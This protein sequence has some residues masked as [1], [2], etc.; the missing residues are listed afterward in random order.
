MIKSPSRPKVII[1]DEL[2]SSSLYRQKRPLLNPKQKILLIFICIFL[3]ACIL[4]ILWNIDQKRREE[5][6][7]REANF[8]FAKVL[9]EK[10]KSF[11]DH[12]QW[13]SVRLFAIYSLL[14]QAKAQKF[15]PMNDIDVPFDSSSIQLDYLTLIN[16]SSYTE[17][18][19]YPLVK[20][21]EKRT[22]LVLDGVTPVPAE[23]YYAI[24]L[25]FYKNSG[26]YNNALEAY[27]SA[28][29]FYNTGENLFKEHRFKDAIPAFKKSLQIRP[30]CKEALNQLGWSY[31][32]IGERGK[33]NQ[34]YKKAK[35]LDFDFYTRWNSKQW[36]N[37]GDSQ[38]KDKKYSKAVQSYKEALK[39]DSSFYPAWDN[40]GKT[41]ETLQQ[42]DKAIKLYKKALR[43]V[44]DSAPEWRGKSLYNEGLK[45]YT[46]EDIDTA[47]SRFKLALQEYP[48]LDRAWLKLADA[49]N[50]G[51]RIIYR[52]TSCDFYFN[53]AD[54]KKVLI[55][56][57]RAANLNMVIHHDTSGSITCR[58]DQVRWDKALDLF[59]KINNAGKWQVGDIYL[60]GSI[61]LVQ[62]LIESNDISIN[63]P[64]PSKKEGKRLDLS[65]F[66]ADAHYVMQNIAQKAGLKIIIDPSINI[67]ITCRLNQVPWY[68]AI[69][70]L[71]P[72]NDLAYFRLGKLLRIGKK[73]DIEKLVGNEQGMLDIT[74][75]LLKLDPG[76]VNFKDEKGKTM[77][78]YAA[79]KG[80]AQLTKYLISRGARVNIRDKWNFTPLHEAADKAVAEI[81]IDNGALVN[82]QSNS[83]LSPLQTAV[84]GL[85][86]ET[87]RF[88]V[89]K[90][91]NSNFFLDAAIG[92]LD[93]I[94]KQVSRNPSIVNNKGMG[95]WT[96]LHHATV[97]GQYPTVEFLISKGADLNALTS[98]GE[99]PLHLAVSRGH[100]SI[101]KLFIINGAKL[102]EKDKYGQTPLQIAKANEFKEIIKLLKK[103]GAQ[104]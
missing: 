53:R 64:H 72:L 18:E 95:D 98:K 63:N 1:S 74:R 77:L 33:S 27:H 62:K 12:Q 11:A 31:L 39:I 3:I 67:S 48:G 58:L 9:K 91:A 52:G 25:D 57:A 100:T 80:Y 94:K 68:T 37:L 47:I 102:N 82:I 54:L 61:P 35:E 96:P 20:D 90:R 8:N 29:D 45:N 2:H 70:V 43:H 66:E 15:L 60:I 22:G 44:P 83:G 84:Y 85:R 51:K 103:Y 75:S 76:H 5:D 88:L 34:I 23:I 99:S 40:L 55:F 65:F 17:A 97:T 73:A 42:F 78:F 87:A 59:L 69:D 56:I 16:R 71:L 79:K 38:N 81:L 19:V 101:V 104:E 30:Q 14:Y 7:A 26:R 28:L 92:R 93:Q 89:E 32:R 50:Y 86:I 4:F 49:Y 24:D 46:S 6:I 41:Y 21:I 36:V 10:A 13:V